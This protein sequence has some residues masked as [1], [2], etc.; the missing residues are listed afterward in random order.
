MYPMLSKLASNSN[1]QKT[2]KALSAK[3]CVERI[4]VRDGSD[5]Q[6]LGS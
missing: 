3:K 4:K 1:E 2:L 6:S 5:L